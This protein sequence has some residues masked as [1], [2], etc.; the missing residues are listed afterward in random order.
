[1]RNTYIYVAHAIVV[2]ATAYFASISGLANWYSVIAIGLPLV[3]SMVPKLSGYSYTVNVRLL[4]PISVGLLCIS[5]FHYFPIFMADPTGTDLARY[6]LTADVGGVAQDFFQVNPIFKDAVSVL[7][8]ICAAFLLWKGLSDFDELKHVLYEEA[9]ELRSISDYT[10]Y[11]LASGEPETNERT[12]RS[13]REQL[14]TYA[15]NML[16][17]NRIVANAE[18]EGVMETCLLEIGKLKTADMNDQIALEEIMKALNRVSILRSRRTVCIEKRMSPFILG[19]MFI[20]SIT[21]V[22]SFFG[23]ASGEINIDYVYVFLLP[24]FYTSIFMT[25]LDLSSP[26]DG[27]WAIKLEAV[28]GVCNKL[29]QQLN[30][31]MLEA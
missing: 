21:M 2:V 9:N 22:A 18:N 12:V 20:M 23:K 17:G 8:A 1:M 31:K 29:E 16:K 4:F 24:A 5:L 10:T 28:N 6:G 13:I 15:T 26:F 25:L 14:L 19:L 27:Y 11:F 30:G 3:L 7:Y